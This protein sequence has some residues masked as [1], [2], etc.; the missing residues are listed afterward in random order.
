M[1]IALAGINPERMV[2]FKLQL[3]LE[4]KKNIF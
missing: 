2:T 4:E 3:L 1:V